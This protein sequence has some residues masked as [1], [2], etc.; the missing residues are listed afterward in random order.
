MSEIDNFDLGSM[1]NYGSDMGSGGD[2]S[3][4]SA[5]A[6]AGADASNYTSQDQYK[7]QSPISSSGWFDP[8]KI[9]AAIN[10]QGAGADNRTV[11]QGGYLSSILNPLS[12]VT[13]QP[14][15][16]L[17]NYSYQSGGDSDQTNT[18]TYWNPGTYTSNGMTLNPL[19]YSK[20][21][22]TSSDESSFAAHQRELASQYGF[23]PNGNYLVGNFENPTGNGDKDQVSA[24]YK[25]DSNGNANPLGA[26]NTYA[27]HD[28]VD[29]NR[30]AAI[31][32]AIAAATAGYGA[33]ASGA[34]GAGAGAGVGAGATGATNAAL[35]ESALG[36]T[37]YGL[38]SAGLGGSALGATNA[39]LI[40][41][42]LQ[43]PGY[44]ASSAGIGGGAGQ[45][46][47]TLA[48]LGQSAG[49][50]ALTNGGMT[51]LRGGDLNDILKGAG[52]GA[53]GGGLSYGVDAYNPGSYATDNPDWQRVV[54]RGVTGAGSSAIGG[55]NPLVGAAMGS[56]TQAGNVVGNNLWNNYVN[57]PNASG[58]ETMPDFNVSGESSSPVRDWFANNNQQ[59]AAPMGYTNSDELNTSLGNN[60]SS[61]LYNPDFVSTGSAPS[62]ET[63]TGNPFKALM[64]QAL[65]AQA[66]GKTGSPQFGDM[67]G[68]LMG[69]YSA[70]QQR[71]KLGELRG[72]LQDMF[73]PN[74]SYAQQLGQQLAR[75]D[76]AA[77]RRSQYGPRE[78]ELQAKLAEMNSRNAPTIQ[79]LIGGERDARDRGLSNILRFGQQSGI[80]QGIG[81]GLQQLFQQYSNGGW[82]S[83]NQFGNQD[84]GLNF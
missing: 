31:T 37:G 15:S 61:S 53:I 12:N 44:G 43:T 5:T 58:G 24:Y 21:D 19:G 18:G 29:F 1:Y 70:Y 32:A 66:G 38:S 46:G 3:G 42:A 33:Y 71:K 80:N 47:F 41:S 8:A 27:P 39:A 59:S 10:A 78:V 36:T 34:V 72:G 4:A 52:Y 62:Q 45:S 28:W 73:G 60:T 84:M 20:G 14:G 68:S 64:S 17:Q 55:G 49:R 74:S 75:R 65:S 67:A 40:D 13:Y 9:Q 51:A 35:I 82:G 69:L 7:K 25:L 11:L 2:M 57:S 48:G 76:A 63:N 50:G 81:N 22:T 23:D 30:Q 16:G 77:G 83:G 6:L 79:N 26:M 56:G 54:N